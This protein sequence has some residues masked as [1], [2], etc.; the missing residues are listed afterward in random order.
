[1]RFLTSIALAALLLASCAES[2]TPSDSGDAD[3]AASDAARTADME[4]SRPDAGGEQQDTGEHPPADAL[5]S[6][7]LQDTLTESDHADLA[8]D[9]AQLPGDTSQQET[10][11]DVA[12]VPPVPDFQLAF[13]KPE[14]GE[15]CSGSLL[16]LL[17]PEPMPELKVDSLTV[18][19]N[20]EWVFSDTKLPTSF[21]LDTRQYQATVLKFEAHAAAGDKNAD[22]VLTV[23]VDNPPFRFK[24]V[25][26]KK[27]L[28]SNGE[29]ISLFVTTGKPG[30]EL[31][32]DFGA[33]DSNYAAGQEEIYEIGG[34]KYT[35]THTV[36]EANETG[37]GTYMVPVQAAND[38][39]SVEHGG[40]EL[41]LENTPP[42][43][44][45][46]EGGI[47]VAGTMPEP[48]AGWDSPIDSVG[49]NEFI[50]TGGSGKL[51]VSFQDYAY[52]EEII[53]ILV[54]VEGYSG[55][56]QKPLA[57][58]GGEEELLL[59]LRPFPQPEVPP[60]QLQFKVA[61]MDVAGRV[62][63]AQ[64]YQMSVET[65]GSGDVQ[66]S[67]SWDTETDVDLHVVEP[68]GEELWYGDKNSNSGG[69]L[70]LDSNPAC[71][72][73]GVNNENV[74]WPEGGAPIGT[75]IVRVDF[76]S[77]CSNCSGLCGAN[78]TVT[79]HYCGELELFEGSF[80]P[81]TDDAGD[82]GSGVEIT[83]F[84]NESCGRIIRGT[85]R[86]EDKTIGPDGFSAATWKPARYVVVELRRSSD[87]AL[88]A[89]GSTDRF[90]SYELQFSNKES[91]GIY[92]VTYSQTDF[93]EGLRPI[94]VMNHPKFD[95]IY[96]V[97][98]PSID[99]SLVEIPQLDFDVP[100][101][102]G[103]GAFNVLDVLVDGYDLIRLKTG[104]DIGQLH[105]YWATGSDTTD[106]LYCSEYFYGLGICSEKGALSVQGKDSDRDEY[107]DMVILKEFFK[108]ALEQ[109]SLDDNPG[110]YHDGTRDDPRRAWSEGVSTFFA[111]D[112]LGRRHFVNSRPQGVYVVDNLETM[113]TPF[114]F[115]TLDG[116]MFAPL[117]EHLVSAV[118]WD[119]ADGP[120]EESNDE[121]EGKRMGIYDAIF[122]YLPSAYFADRGFAGVDLVDFLDG[123]FC[124]GWAEAPAVE[125]IVNGERDFA[126]D[127]AGPEECIH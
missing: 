31:T 103:G 117:S 8:G 112:V 17:T 90:G 24:H 96:S 26:A 105:V 101:V 21:V 12:D 115:S 44:V 35:I 47:F 110:G 19:V 61:V 100:E 55:Y 60:S 45:R 81:G 122:N 85:I 121:M 30:L 50:I 53:G 75:Y 98:S 36:S 33:L 88:L 71:A 14:E 87:G 27:Y 102:V 56:Y 46:M 91:P 22:A 39:Y 111:S 127:Y 114:A 5:A 79:V 113:P 10:T 125:Q 28:Y 120:D 1:M 3:G 11:L 86:Y 78:Y 106:T 49:G 62:C 51:D 72:I 52:P 107:D 7:S 95:V 92:I 29:E 18:E 9:Q 13:H 66:V 37:D 23:A 16:V 97:A 68:S 84:S 109:V 65:V 83:T 104:K 76:Y 94:A 42:L 80:A 77:D 20:G 116:T 89:S 82:E 43:P 119:L 48:T 67:V 70:D 25:S 126:Y 57:G 63:D 32:A 99:E 73:D 58:S 118:L 124:R 41:T 38:D 123:W 40:L 6:D 64:D 59:L 4:R 69:E 93:N 2:D 74:F 54:G 34:G 108:F 15:T